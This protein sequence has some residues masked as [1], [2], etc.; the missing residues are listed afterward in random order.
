M[1]YMRRLHDCNVHGY[2][3][4]EQGAYFLGARSFG[5]VI[6]FLTIFSTLFSG[7]TVVLAPRRG[8]A[9]GAVEG[10]AGP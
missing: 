1:Y 7:I 8:S 4:D 5:R 2:I 9:R 3:G 10:V 6:L